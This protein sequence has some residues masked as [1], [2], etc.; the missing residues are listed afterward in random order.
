MISIPLAAAIG[1]AVG[2]AA[3]G[4]ASAM[5]HGAIGLDVALSHIPTESQ[6]YTVV[7]AVK[8]ALLGGAA[9]GGIGA[10]V[11][12]AAKGLSAA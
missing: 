8:D 6:G 3:L 4:V 10:A 9:G 11:A 12:A 7:S 2:A 1:A 5:T